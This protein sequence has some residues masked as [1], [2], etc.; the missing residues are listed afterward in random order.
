MSRRAKNASAG[1]GAVDLIEEAVHLLRSAPAGTLLAYYAGTVPFALGVLFFWAHTTWFAPSGAGV[2]WSSLL[3]VLFFAAMKAAQAEFCSRLL[4]QR[5][6]AETP[7]L[8]LARFRRL[9]GVQLRLQAWSLFTLP[10]A[11]VLSVPFGWV[12]AYFQN[13]SV[14]GD[15]E[16]AAETARAQAMLWPAQNHVAL[17]ILSAL[18]ICAWA[19]LAAA[20]WLVPWLANRLLGIENIF[21]LSGG[22]FFNTTFLASVTVLTWLAIDPLVKAFYTLRIFHGRS[23]RTGEDLRMELRFARGPKIA[24]RAAALAVFLAV[25]CAA[26]SRLR[27]AETPAAPA[28]SSAEL[29][30]AIERTLADSDFQWRL[31]P[32]PAE[33]PADETGFLAT[34][35]RKVNEFFHTAYRWAQ[36]FVEWFMDLFPSR[37]GSRAK[38]KASGSMF[39]WGDLLRVVIILS[40][41]F[42]LGLLVL[43]WKRSRDFASPVVQ[44][45]A[46]VVTAP[47]LQDEN[48]QAGQL[49]ADGWLALAREKI[50]AG[51]WR[52]ALRA[53]Y[54]ATLAR[55]AAEG[56]VSLARFKTNLDYERELKRRALA[57]HDIVTRFSMR[58]RDF[59]AAWYG[60]APTLET[61]ARSWL[62]ELETPTLP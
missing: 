41:V 59:E 39:F 31:R 5:L 36:D 15:S 56:L 2:A 3:L 47:D 30:T 44:A 42:I 35:A 20:F 45:R 21:G 16:D 60:R 25:A 37:D 32:A 13:A 50:A 23:R 58:R 61:D 12:F 57:R 34:F 28:V 51:E 62:A 10:F 49:P 55:L 18:A 14:M 11:L 4:A 38:P 6:D 19:N 33:K 9:A 43:V 22:W 7:P 53:L 46:A 40:I 24:I 8:T 29:E 26:P 52:L 27:A 1:P 48:T 54:L 17:L